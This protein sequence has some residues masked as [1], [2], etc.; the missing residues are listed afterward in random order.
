MSD[1]IRYL[2]EEIS[3]QDVKA[4]DWFL[5]TAYSKMQKER[6]RLKKML[7]KKEPELDQE[8]SLSVL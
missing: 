2:A 8:N 5:L 4:V 3:K 7:S 1:N 6:E